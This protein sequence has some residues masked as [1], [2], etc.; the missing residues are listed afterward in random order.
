MLSKF[1]QKNLVNMVMLTLIASSSLWIFFNETRPIIL[2]SKFVETGKISNIFNTDRYSQY[3]ANMPDLKN[4]FSKGARLIENHS[5]QNIGLIFDG[6][7]WEYPIW[8]SFKDKVRIEHIQVDNNSKKY[9][10][11]QRYDDFTPCALISDKK[12]NFAKNQLSYQGLTYDRL[13]ESQGLA[14]FIA[15]NYLRKIS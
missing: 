12:G 15:R 14:V 4:S 6:L 5:C 10:Q 7:N 11:N 8:V 3:F 1:R 13:P 9:F 2:N